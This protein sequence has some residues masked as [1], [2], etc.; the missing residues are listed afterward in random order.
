MKPTVQCS[1]GRWGLRGLERNSGW[2]GG[3]GVK[4]WAPP[5][6][7]IAHQAQEA[8]GRAGRQGSSQNWGKAG[9]S[10]QAGLLATREIGTHVP[11]R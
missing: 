10:P 7:L 3:G 6:P 8:G 1:G 9:R 2:V 4:E 5:R 11:R